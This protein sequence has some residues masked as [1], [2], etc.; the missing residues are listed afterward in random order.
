MGVA[1]DEVAVARVAAACSRGAHTV[2]VSRAGNAERGAAGPNRGAYTGA[3]CP[4]IA[5]SGDAGCTGAADEPEL[6]VQGGR[7][8]LGDGP[9]NYHLRARWPVHAGGR[10][11]ETDQS[12]Y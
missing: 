8:V 1:D 5:A 12:T 10:D 6:V 9:G 3:G 11:G 7:G 4:G 2:A